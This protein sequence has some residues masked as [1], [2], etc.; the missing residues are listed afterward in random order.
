MSFYPCRGGGNE[1]WPK[2]VKQV[3]TRSVWS[4][5]SV[6]DVRKIKS[7]TVTYY[8]RSGV[9]RLIYKLANDVDQFLSGF[10]DNNDN[11]WSLSLPETNTTSITRTIDVSNF[12][13]I[14][15]APRDSGHMIWEIIDVT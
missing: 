14:G 11:T 10:L 13:Y 6:F 1:N 3:G 7:V 8:A 9:E 5:T 15:I 4:I 2:L 12:D